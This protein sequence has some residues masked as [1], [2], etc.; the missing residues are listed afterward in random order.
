M[1]QYFYKSVKQEWDEQL[2]LYKREFYNKKDC[3]D[4]KIIVQHIGIWLCLG[5]TTK[6]LCSSASILGIT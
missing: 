6:C 4:M 5:G 3:R 2:F 1:G